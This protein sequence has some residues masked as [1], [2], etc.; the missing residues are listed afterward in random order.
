MFL[1][2]GTAGSVGFPTPIP[3][4]LP[5]L[6][7]ALDHPPDNALE[8]CSHVFRRRNEADVRTYINLIIM[9]V[10][11]D[12]QGFQTSGDMTGTSQRPSTPPA[13]IARRSAFNEVSMS[14]T[15]HIN[16]APVKIVGR[17]DIGFGL[18][19]SQ[20]PSLDTYLAV[21]ETKGSGA[22]LESGFTQ[23]LVYLSI[24]HRARARKLPLRPDTNVNSTVYGVLSDGMYYVFVCLDN[25]STVS[26]PSSLLPTQA[27]NP[28]SPAAP[29]SIYAARRRRSLTT[30]ATA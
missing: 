28:R 17:F 12:V 21:L 18:S 1:P 15:V 10:L 27:D 26:V 19:D 7:T 22:S 30:S 2:G 6:L 3:V 8:L 23:L 20:D 29:S 25:T 4:Q 13:T 11:R 9:D 14:T 24:V 5:S 16:N